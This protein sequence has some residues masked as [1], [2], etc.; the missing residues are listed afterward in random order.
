M[1]LREVFRDRWIVVV[2]KPAGL[3]TQPPQ[4]GGDNVHDRLRASGGYVALH[5]RLDAAA[6]GLLLFGLD[7]AVN[8]ALAQAFRTH[9]IARTYLAIACGDV[10]DDVWDRPVEGKTARTRVEVVGR[11]GGRCALRL[12]PETGRKHQ[13]R[14]HAALAGAPLLGDRVYGGDPA[15]RLA[16]HATG[17]AFAHPATNEPIVLSSPLPDELA[18]AWAAAGGDQR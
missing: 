4:G 2:D 11:G 17:L 10:L 8:A 15:E 16:L 6:S 12:R 1:T 7:R 5:H 13:L 14:V 3:P 18:A 9:A